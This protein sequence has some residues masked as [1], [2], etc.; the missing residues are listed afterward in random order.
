MSTECTTAEQPGILTTRV[1][2]TPINGIFSIVYG[3]AVTARIA[4]GTFFV[5]IICDPVTALPG[6]LGI[7]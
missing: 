3:L 5:G 2:I 1:L 7:F 6:D 4:L